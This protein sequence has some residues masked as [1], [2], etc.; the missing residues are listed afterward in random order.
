M[1]LGGESKSALGPPV[2][3]PA[4]ELVPQGGLSVLPVLCGCGCGVWV[5]VWVWCPRLQESHFPQGAQPALPVEVLELRVASW[6]PTCLGGRKII[7]PVPSAGLPGTAGAS[8]LQSLPCLTSPGLRKDPRS[9]AN[10]HS[11]GLSH[12]RERGQVNFFF[13]I[14][15]YRLVLEKEGGRDSLP[16]VFLHP[17]VASCM[18]LD[19]GSN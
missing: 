3:I 6:G 8:A 9:G 7:L 15:I 4:C 19:L 14:F 1:G 18:C 12:P 5:W 11:M 2:S 16:H 13:L 10:G 17:L